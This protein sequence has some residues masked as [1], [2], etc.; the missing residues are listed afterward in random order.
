MTPKTP[1]N[2]GVGTVEAGWYEVR[3]PL[4]DLAGSRRRQ[5]C[6]RWARS[7]EVGPDGWVGVMHCG[8]VWSCPVCATREWRQRSRELGSVVTLGRER[9]AQLVML[10]A[11]VRHSREQS[12]ADVAKALQDAFR[13]I[14]SQR[15]WKDHTSGQV[16][17][18]EVTHGH[19]GWHPH[20]HAVVALARG[21]TREDLAALSRLWRDTVREAAPAHTPTVAAGWHVRRVKNARGGRYL[22]DALGAELTDANSTKLPRAQGTRTLLDIARAAGAG[23]KAARA[24][25][26]EYAAWSHGRRALCYSRAMSRLRRDVPPEPELASSWTAYVDADS[27]REV[28]RLPWAMR[29]IQLGLRAL[30]PRPPPVAPS[31]PAQQVGNDGPLDNRS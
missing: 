7:P 25:W 15:A 24:L 27:W 23:D 4:R 14:T 28:R 26:A 6:D 13:S 2:V 17:R 21:S 19:H 12:L 11:T 8:S 29:A 18:I 9:G 30:W 16:R 1:A 5:A 22:G 20:I 3:E 10:T 31:L